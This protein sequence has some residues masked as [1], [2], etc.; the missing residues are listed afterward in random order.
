MSDFSPPPCC[1]QV[2]PEWL[3]TLQRLADQVLFGHRLGLVYLP[4]GEGEGHRYSA[5]PT[6][7]SKQLQPAAGG[8]TTT[9]TADPAPPVHGPLRTEPAFS[10]PPHSSDAAAAVPITTPSTTTAAGL[11][12]PPPPDRRLPVTVLSGFL[13]AGK[14]TL[15]QHILRNKQVCA[16][17]NSSVFFMNVI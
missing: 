3:P 17:F 10:P 6:Q 2:P 11:S 16:R 8:T 15:L 7:A 9:G 5:A 13:G 1:L 12:L 4:T 14:T